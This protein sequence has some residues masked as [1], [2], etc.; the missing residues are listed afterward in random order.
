MGTI[1]FADVFYLNTINSIRGAA[2]KT[3]T[4]ALKY[5]AYGV[6]IIIITMIM[7]YPKSFRDY[8]IGIK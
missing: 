7:Y 8:G 3:F 4:L 1:S 2:V 5:W 6:A